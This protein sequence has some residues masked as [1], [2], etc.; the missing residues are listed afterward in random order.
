MVLV[1]CVFFRPPNSLHARSALHRAEFSYTHRHLCE[2]MGLDLEMAIHEHYFEV[3]DVI[4][5][6][7]GAIFN[8]LATT[9][10]ALTANVS[11]CTL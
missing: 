5:K 2:F 7:F 8:G 4:E 3:L 9:Y 6:L 11:P 1:S 10:G